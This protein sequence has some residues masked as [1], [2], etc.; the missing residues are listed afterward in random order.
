MNNETLDF[1]KKIFLK[2]SFKENNT[3]K[4]V[5]P[6]K[7]QY[8]D[9]I[10]YSF[11]EKAIFAAKE[12]ILRKVN[13]QIELNES[14]D[15]KIDE[16]K[17]VKNVLFGPNEI[18]TDALYNLAKAYV[19][20]A[21]MF[22]SIPDKSPE[23]FENKNPNLVE[24]I[25]IDCIEFEN[26]DKHD[27]IFMDLTF[28]Y[29]SREKLEPSV[30]PDDYDKCKAEDYHAVKVASIRI[31]LAVLDIYE[32]PFKYEKP[33]LLAKRGE[34]TF[35]IT[36]LNN[37]DH[38]LFI[39]NEKLATNL[40]MDAFPV[41][42]GRFQLRLAA[43]HNRINE[44]MDKTCSACNYFS[45]KESNCGGADLSLEKLGYCISDKDE[46]TLKNNFFK[47][48]NII[49]RDQDDFKMKLV[50]LWVPEEVAEYFVSTKY[51]WL[52]WAYILVASQLA[53]R[54]IAKDCCKK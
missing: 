19:K 52:E 16:L 27:T 37:I 49:P 30:Y 7:I 33:K 9:A 48:K 51:N 24:N 14:N 17:Y 32:T 2:E 43:I 12:A 3:S 38:R 26:N 40:N 5:F 10:E 20:A 11:Y 29:D 35:E 23:E 47:F 6:F 28:Y 54:D 34:T 42:S 39:S 18:F 41:E 15:T 31:K 4:Q 36:Y 45:Q 44:S 25:N 50:K 21:C 46:E 22:V 1:S 13:H 8:G 53:K